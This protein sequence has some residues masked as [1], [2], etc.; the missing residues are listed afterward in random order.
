VKVGRQLLEKAAVSSS[1]Q[2][3]PPEAKFRREW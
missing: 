1:A 2:R 3:W